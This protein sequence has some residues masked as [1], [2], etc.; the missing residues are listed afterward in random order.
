[1]ENASTVTG[2]ISI[3]YDKQSNHFNNDNNDDNSDDCSIE[4]NN[5]NDMK[6]GNNNDNNNKIF[7]N[8]ERCQVRDNKQS[9]Y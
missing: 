8:Q 9:V 1:V 3:T 4:R 5:N 2:S 7:A 6:L